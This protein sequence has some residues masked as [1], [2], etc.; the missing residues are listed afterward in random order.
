MWPSVVATVCAILLL[1]LLRLFSFVFYCET[2]P[3][4]NAAT[5]WNNWLVQN[6]VNAHVRPV[7]KS[8]VVRI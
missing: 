1:L 2:T 5:L 6:Q 8:W 4:A 3:Q 7:R